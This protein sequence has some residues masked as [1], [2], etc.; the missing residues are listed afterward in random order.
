V[1]YAFFLGRRIYEYTT[2]GKRALKKRLAYYDNMNP[3]MT[4]HF[5]EDRMVSQDIDSVDITPYNKISKV[6]FYSD[7][8]VLYRKD[9]RVTVLDPYGFTKGDAQSFVWFI[10][11]KTTTVNLI[12]ER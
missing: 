9:G 4:N 3:P 12:R 8:I 7:L 5:F 2:Y 11:S 10:Q 1:V 6:E